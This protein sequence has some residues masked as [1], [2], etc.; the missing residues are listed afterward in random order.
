MG[1][2][3][4]KLKNQLLA[5]DALCRT[6]TEILCNGSPESRAGQICEQIRW[7]TKT[8]DVAFFMRHI[9]SN[10]YKFSIGVGEKAMGFG[11]GALELET[12]ELERHIAS[13]SQVASKGKIKVNSS[14]ALSGFRDRYSIILPVK[15]SDE[16]KGLVVCLHNKPFALD[17]SAA[18]NQLAL[19][20][21]QL[22][23]MIEY[24]QEISRLKEK[25][26]SLTLLYEIG[27]KLSSIRDED[28]LLDSILELIE[29]HIKVDRCSLMI[30]EEDRKILRIKRAFGM[31]EVDI[32]SVKVVLGEGIAGYV[33]TGTRPLLIKDI[34]AEKH[35]ISQIDNGDKFRTNSLLSVPLVVQGKT[36][37]VINVN[38]RKDGMPFSEE[39]KDLLVKIGS[40]I[41]AVLQR[42]YLALQ[43]KK[44]KELEE[45]IKRS[46]A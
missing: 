28:K 39:D 37:G 13:T 25:A 44:A 5:F 23:S 26:K 32:D 1:Q 7:V 3:I 43:I 35:L 27:S 38:N 42:S 6:L 16:V 30:V 4:E 29:E 22:G 41:A 14:K 46:M 9:G 33:A 40:E 34:S 20:V 8:Q 11:G 31:P 15:L 45:D 12:E 36:I 18:S 2:S 10:F 21:A 19:L 24:E 17:E